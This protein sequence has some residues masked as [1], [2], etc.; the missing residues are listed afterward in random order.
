MFLLFLTQC[1]LYVFFQCNIFENVKPSFNWEKIK[2]MY[3]IS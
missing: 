2:I 1:R 3:D